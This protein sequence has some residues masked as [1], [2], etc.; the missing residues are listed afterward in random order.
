LEFTAV[1]T[2]RKG[3]ISYQESFWDHSEA[4]EALELSE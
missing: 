3:R 1:Y 2:M 4:L